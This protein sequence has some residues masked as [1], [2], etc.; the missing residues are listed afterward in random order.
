MKFK[1]SFVFVIICSIV[2][3]KCDIP[4]HCLQHQVVGDWIFYQTE[5]VRKSLSQLYQHKC[6][7]FDHT[8]VSEINK[9][10][11][12]ESLF[13]YSFQIHLSKDHD[14]KISQTFPEF[15]GPKVRKGF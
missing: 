7:I 1:T 4:T 12:N 6:G 13:K 2:L 8:K 9:F 5:A 15:S 3:I 11:M 14:V 10:K